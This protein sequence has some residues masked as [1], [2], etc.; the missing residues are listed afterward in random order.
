MDLLWSSE[1]V[2]LLFTFVFSFF[3]SINL[4]MCG[5]AWA[6]L[7]NLIEHYFVGS[8]CWTLI[9][10]RDGVWA[11]PFNSHA[12]RKNPNYKQNMSRLIMTISN[13][14]NS[15]WAWEGGASETTFQMGGQISMG[16]AGKPTPSHA[17]QR[18]QES[19][20]PTPKANLPNEW[21]VFIIAL[22]T[23]CTFL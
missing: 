21:E 17:M 14:D 16:E 5:W 8:Q 10:E 18:C 15:D 7:I 11:N 4:K 22:A 9:H 23:S 6:L 12:R 19:R 2:E 1:F 3:L 13:Y 20:P